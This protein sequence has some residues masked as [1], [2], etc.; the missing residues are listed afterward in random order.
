[1]QFLAGIFS[2]RYGACGLLMS[3]IAPCPALE[4]KPGV[5]NLEIE[6]DHITCRRLDISYVKKTPRP[7]NKKLSSDISKEMVNCI[8]FI[9]YPALLAAPGM[10]A[11]INENRA[12]CT[13]Q[14]PQLEDHLSC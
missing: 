8:I 9:F 1:M 4:R 10:K 2:Q 14:L 13:L 5:H 11:K 3:V 6:L 12:P 7:P